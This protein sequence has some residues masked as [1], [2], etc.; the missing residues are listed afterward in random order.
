VL[1]GLEIDEADFGSA[2]SL[3]ALNELVYAAR[4]WDVF[5]T[6]SPRFLPALSRGVA[7]LDLGPARRM[8]LVLP[9]KFCK[10]V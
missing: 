3:P 8:V 6:D 10:H 1:I 4:G 2:V 5:G 7:F 9:L